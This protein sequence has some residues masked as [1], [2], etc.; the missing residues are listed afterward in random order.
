MY[1]C[2]QDLALHLPKCTVVLVLVPMHYSTHNYAVL[3]YA[4]VYQHNGYIKIEKNNG[5]T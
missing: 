5:Q 3:D 4:K 1:K 2:T